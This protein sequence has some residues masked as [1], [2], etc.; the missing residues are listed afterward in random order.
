MNLKTPPGEP[1]SGLPAQSYGF[2]CQPDGSFLIESV[3][4]GIYR[5]TLSLNS[6]NEKVDEIIN[7]QEEML[8]QLMKDLSV[9][10]E[11]IDLGT[12]TLESTTPQ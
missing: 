3:L 8:G 6:K 4:P 5:L 7:V 12:I 2:F 11:D 1:T 9:D 10:T